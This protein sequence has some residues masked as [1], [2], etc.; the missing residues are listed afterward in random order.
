MLQIISRSK[1]AS[2]LSW[3]VRCAV[4]VV[5]VTG[6]V[7]LAG[8]TRDYYRRTA[9]D[10]TYEILKEKAVDERWQQESFDITPDPRSRFFDPTYPDNPPLPPDD[11]TANQSMVS[12]YA[13]PL[14]QLSNER[15]QNDNDENP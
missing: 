1:H 7:G 13:M 8:C 10:Q 3:C 4:V 2:R 6:V 15:T 9:D 5:V 14:S 12:A 11:P